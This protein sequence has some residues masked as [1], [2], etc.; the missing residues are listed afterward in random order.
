MWLR[1]WGT[2]EVQIEGIDLQVS[3]SFFVILYLFYSTFS[4]FSLLYHATLP[5]P[6]YTHTTHI[7]P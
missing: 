3:F 1:I 7:P 5:S 4:D 6:F 2:G